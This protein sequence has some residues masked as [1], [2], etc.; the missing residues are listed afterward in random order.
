MRLPPRTH[1]S[2]V[3]PAGSTVPSA[4]RMLTVT[5]GTGRPAEP[6]SAPPRA[7]SSGPSTLTSAALSV[8]P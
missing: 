4:D 5:P 3:S 6:S 1:T 7:W 8:I 2:P